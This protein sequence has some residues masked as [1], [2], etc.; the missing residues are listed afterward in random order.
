MKYFPY[1]TVN[2]VDREQIVQNDNF[3]SYLNKISFIL[4]FCRNL[5]NNNNEKISKI[6][7]I[8]GK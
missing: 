2:L 5:K 4:R 6:K 8:G 1:V 7:L 3:Y